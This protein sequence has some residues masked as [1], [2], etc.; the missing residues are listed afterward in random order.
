MEAR[1][2]ER[3]SISSVGPRRDLARWRAHDKEGIGRVYGHVA[4]GI[5]AHLDN[6]FKHFYRQGRQGGSPGFPHFKREVTWRW[7][8][9]SNG[10][11]A[12]VPGRNG[13]HRLHLSM[14]GDLPIQV[15]QALPLKRSERVNNAP[16]RVHAPEDSSS[17]AARTS[18]G[19]C[20]FR[21]TN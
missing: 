14:V 17:T 10:S 15:P 21:T 2:K 16:L 8:P 1:R 4:Q 6:A 12:V 7:Y 3:R 5:L 19:T 20:H 11:A 13:T 9:D 18:S